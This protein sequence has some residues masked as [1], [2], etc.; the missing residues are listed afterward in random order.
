VTPDG[1]GEGVEELHHTVEEL[2]HENEALRAS[3]GNGGAPR[4]RGRRILSW[5]LLV[6]A[7][8]LA[9]VSVFVVFARNQLLNTDTYVNTV[10]PL[11]SDPAIQTQVAKQVSENLIARTN[12][13]SRVKNA[14]PAKAGFL[15]TPIT[16]GL[17][18]ATNEI[19]LK[20]VQSKQFY[21]IWVGAN[22]TAHK[23][24]VA[25][26]TGSNEGSISSKNGKVTIDL[27]QVEVQVKKR[28]DARGIT[29]FDKIPAVKGINFVLF[30]ST[31]LTKV[32]RV[33]KVLNDLAIV[34]PIITLL[35][36]AGAVILARNRRRGLVRAAT[37]LALSMAV[38]LVVLAV[39]RNQY[40]SGLSPN[41]SVAAN[42]AVI[43]TVSAFLI[44]SI[45]TIMIVAALV[46][47]VAILAG[48]ARIRSWVAARRWPRWTT[49]GPV[50][51]FVAEHRRGLQWAVLALG[52]LLVVV[53]SNP[54][55][56]V[57]VVVVLVTF[58]VIG[59]VGLLA[60]RRPA[61]AVAAATGGGQGPGPEARVVP[62]D[63][64]PDPAGN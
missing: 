56:L 4:H 38:V 43:S 41:Q 47:V 55:T 42:E 16:S 5:V 33:V 49:E 48:N 22:R 18:T 46:A 63:E 27:S 23:Q 52:L 21:T 9:V 2:R 29:V 31:S 44:D 19:A 53:W 61:P 1:E 39:A 32:Q 59:L 37:G 24:L 15:A 58:A 7:C 50:H 34:L 36:L 20:A 17:E 14:L 6:L 25:L 28:L 40:I 11:A 12:V 64:D 3:G 45:R 57:V 54:T 26:L 35:L 60:G 8:I 51:D 10:A 30:Q 13:Q 62:V